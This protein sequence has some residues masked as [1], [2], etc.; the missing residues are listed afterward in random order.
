MKE[1]KFMATSKK[2]SASKAKPSNPKLKSELS[3]DKS[4]KAESKKSEPGSEDLSRKAKSKKVEHKKQE[5]T[6]TLAHAAVAS[7]DAPSTSSKELARK[8]KSEKAE[9]KHQELAEAVA[10]ARSTAQEM[11]SNQSGNPEKSYFQDLGARIAQRAYEL[12]EQRGRVHGHD[13]EDWLEAERQI[14]SAEQS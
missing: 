14:L 9:R 8:A 4:K 13:F 12:H 10:P 1:D 11:P 2:D 6:N 7:H 5:L 3:Q